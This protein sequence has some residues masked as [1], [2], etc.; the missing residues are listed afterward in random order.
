MTIQ[1]M[2]L[3]IE[4]EPALAAWLAA[5]LAISYIIK[6]SFNYYQSKIS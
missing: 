1:F 6:I 4:M 2:L 3:H 5:V